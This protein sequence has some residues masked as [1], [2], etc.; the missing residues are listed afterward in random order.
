MRDSDVAR[1]IE[2]MTNNRKKMKFALASDV[3][4]EFGPLELKNTENADVLVLAG[5]ICVAKDL[6][7]KDDVQFDRFDRNKKIHEFFQQACA[8]FPH[9]IYTAGN[10]EHYH[11]DFNDT[12]RN[13]RSYLGYLENLHILDKQ[14]VKIEDVT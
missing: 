2:R 5:D 9:V 4:L 7:E 14:S 6:R 12:Y 10:H 11:G 8:E 13:L 1:E 3:H